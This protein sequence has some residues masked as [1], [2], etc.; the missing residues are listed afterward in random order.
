MKK[1]VFVP[2]IPITSFVIHESLPAEVLRKR[3]FWEKKYC[4]CERSLLCVLFDISFSQSVQLK[5]HNYKYTSTHTDENLFNFKQRVKSFSHLRSLFKLK[6]PKR[7]NADGKTLNCEY[8]EKP[9]TQSYLKIHQRTHTGEKPFF[10]ELCDKSFAQ[11]SSLNR[12][13]RTHTGE[14]PF[15]CELCDKSFAQSGQLKTHQKHILVR[16]HS[17]VISV[18]NLFHYYII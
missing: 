2:N 7:I 8:C 17:I 13:T 3:A 5:T 12:H 11:K 14:K 4:P 6:M 10:C 15:L 18:R 9:F 16:N 1:A